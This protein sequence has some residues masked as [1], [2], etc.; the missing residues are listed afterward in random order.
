MELFTKKQILLFHTFYRFGGDGILVCSVANMPSQLPTEATD[1]FG[2]ILA[3]MISEMVS[4][5]AYYNNLKRKTHLDTFSKF[6]IGYTKKLLA[7][8]S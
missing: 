7:N 1:S 5:M 4:F 2:D 6:P 8:T 3:P